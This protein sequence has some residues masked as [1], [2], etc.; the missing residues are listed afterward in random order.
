LW[1]QAVF[2]VKGSNKRF[3]QVKDSYVTDADDLAKRSVL[4]GDAFLPSAS[5]SWRFRSREVEPYMPSQ[6]RG[7][8]WFS[9]NKVSKEQYK[10]MVER[11]AA[12][13]PPPPARPPSIADADAPAGEDAPPRKTPKERMD[14][15]W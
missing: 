9:V 11:R 2:Q 7:L 12:A 10:E 14:E 15:N 8:P 3:P 4:D 13:L 6:G 5:G 1:L